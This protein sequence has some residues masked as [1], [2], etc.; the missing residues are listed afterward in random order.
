MYQQ[1]VLLNQQ[2]VQRKL[3]SHGLSLSSDDAKLFTAEELNEL[4][5]ADIRDL[6]AELGY[7]LTK[8]KKAEIIEEFLQQQG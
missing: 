6:A 4:T 8:T 5:I 3:I 7:D 1:K 2:K